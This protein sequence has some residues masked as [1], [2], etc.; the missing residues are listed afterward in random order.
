[1]PN[2]K[3]ATHLLTKE[4]LQYPRGPD[5]WYIFK[6]NIQFSDSCMYL[7]EFTSVMFFKKIIKFAT[8]CLPLKPDWKKSLFT[9]DTLPIS[10]GKLQCFGVKN[11]RA[12]RNF[13]NHFN[14][15]FLICCPSKAQITQGTSPQSH[16]CLV[17]GLAP[18][19]MEF[20]C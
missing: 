10:S 5:N 15:N 3:K 6:L 8:Q 12:I 13:R 7:E 1:M 19:P 11:F 4:S 16:S 20:G 18:S 14:S 2:G 9:L 17:A